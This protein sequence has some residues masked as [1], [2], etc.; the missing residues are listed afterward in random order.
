MVP[1]CV[2]SLKSLV[3]LLFSLC[4]ILLLHTASARPYILRQYFFPDEDMVTSIFFFLFFP[5]FSIVY[6]IGEGGFGGRS[7]DKLKSLSCWVW[8]LPVTDLVNHFIIS[9]GV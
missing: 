2:V 6:L 5:I 3:L 9:P 1:N 8:E 7:I 4:L